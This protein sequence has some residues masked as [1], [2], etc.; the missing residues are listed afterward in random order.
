[1]PP[2]EARRAAYDAAVRA[3]IEAAPPVRPAERERLAR[4][5]R[6]SGS[7]LVFERLAEADAA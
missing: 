6:A 7:E 1:M 5:W 3:A 2:T 4:V